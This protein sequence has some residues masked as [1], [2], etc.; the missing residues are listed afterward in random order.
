MEIEAGHVFSVGG[1]LSAVF[2][3]DVKLTRRIPSHSN[4]PTAN[5]ARQTSSAPTLVLASASQVTCVVMQTSP[6]GT[7]CVLRVGDLEGKEGLRPKGVVDAPG[8][9]PAAGR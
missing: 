1:P 3:R 5:T 2:N 9:P 4:D 8:S 6:E 7:R